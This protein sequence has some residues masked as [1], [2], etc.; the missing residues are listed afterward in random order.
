MKGQAVVAD[1]QPSQCVVL[2][3]RFQLQL[4]YAVLVVDMPSNSRCSS[5]RRHT[6]HNAPDGSAVETSR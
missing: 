5:D 1:T 2:P 3:L 4:T 6:T